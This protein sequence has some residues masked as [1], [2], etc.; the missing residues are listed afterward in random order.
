MPPQKPEVNSEYMGSPKK[1]Q[2][3]RP[4]MQMTIEHSNQTGE[5]KGPGQSRGQECQGTA[6]S[7]K[8]T[9][10]QAKDGAPHASVLRS[11]DA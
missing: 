9:P 5:E 11:N 10:V 2:N 6:G 8:L 1:T 3:P 7:E 4:H